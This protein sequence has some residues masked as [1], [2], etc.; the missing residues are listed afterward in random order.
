MP[1]APEGEAAG[2]IAA[3]ARFAGLGRGPLPWTAADLD[4]AEVA[5]TRA[6]DPRPRQAALGALVRLADAPRRVAAWQVAARDPDAAVRRRAAEL[7]PAV[8]HPADD[9]IR[10]LLAD[11]D[12]LVAEAAAAAAGEIT[13]PPDARAT[14]VDVLATTTRDHPDPLVREAA[15]AALGALGDPAGLAAILAACHD[16]PP[17][18]RRAVL[19]LAPFDGP[20]VDATLAAALTDPDWQVRQAAEDLS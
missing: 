17:I 8:D 11:A 10:A 12:P 1:E 13:W 6:G 18:R 14:L 15:V 2:A 4:A 20:E 16:R 3:A 5:L 7:A 9:A 19:A